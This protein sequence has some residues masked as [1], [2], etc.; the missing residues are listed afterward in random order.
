MAISTDEHGTIPIPAAAVSKKSS[1]VSV[2]NSADEGQQLLHQNGDLVHIEKTNFEYEITGDDH[3]TYFL[4]ANITTWHVNIDLLFSTNV[5][6]DFR[7]QASVPVYWTNGYWNETQ[8]L[9]VKLSK[10]KNVLHFDRIADK[11]LMI[12]DFFL[13]KTKPVIP[14]P[15]PGQVPAPTPPPTPFSDYIEL[16]KGKTCASQGI[17]SLEEKDCGI[18]S[19]Y[20]GYKYTGVRQREFFSGC[21]CLVSGQYAGNCNFNS[22]ASADQLN[23]DARALCSR[24][25]YAADSSVFLI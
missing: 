8:P 6:S 20:L 17:S 12:K 4:T 11:P 23:D 7:D 18:A 15:D 3:A 25:Q 21:F 9:E 24:H 1:S 2:M 5:S 14:A 19:D 10:G 16:S 13:Y 22:N